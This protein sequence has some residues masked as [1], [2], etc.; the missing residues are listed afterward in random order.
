M[1]MEMSNALIIGFHTQP[2]ATYGFWSTFYKWTSLHWESF[3]YN[4]FLFMTYA[5]SQFPI[6]LFTE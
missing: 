4:S 3:F 1:K 2:F 5:T 6:I